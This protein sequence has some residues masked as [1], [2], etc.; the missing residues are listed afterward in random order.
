MLKKDKIKVVV[1]AILLTAI[2]ITYFL[3]GKESPITKY[4]SGACLIVWL[5]TMFIVNKKYN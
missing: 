1:I 3:L 5:A 4:V 2:A